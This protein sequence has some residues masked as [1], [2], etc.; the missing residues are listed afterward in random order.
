MDETAH[1]LK[2]EDDGGNDALRTVT[3]VDL[4]V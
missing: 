1:T 3:K 4:T 2:T